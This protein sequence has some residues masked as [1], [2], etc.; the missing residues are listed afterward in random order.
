MPT[1]LLFYLI[2]LPA[3]FVIGLGK[4]AFGGGLAIIGVPL[5][6]LVTDPVDATIIVA[7][8]ASTTDIFALQAFPS[9]TWSW[10]DI[11]WIAPGMLVGIALGA[12]FFVLVDARILVLGI[13]LVTLAFAARY[14]LQE[15]FRT[16]S[17]APVAPLK[18]MFFGGVGGFT[19]FISHAAAPPISVYLLPRGLPK[20]VYAG[21]MVALLTFSNIFKII[22]YIWFGIQRPEALW[23]TL[24]LLPAIPLGVWFGKVL[25]DR[26]D[27]DRLYFWCYLLV[28]AAGL[29]LLADSL[30]KLLA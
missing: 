2:G 15:R 3:V 9:R 23:Q 18:A 19:T 26:L 27:A 22:P 21:T 6:A 17:G 20:S 16:G 24:P 13:A 30:L 29:K 1:D 14:F 7:V 5:L 12:L 25:H 10:P 11:V 8:V 28:A 4:G